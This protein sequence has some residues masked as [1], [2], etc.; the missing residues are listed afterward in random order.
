MK[1]QKASKVIYLE[2]IEHYSGDVNVANDLQQIESS[3]HRLEVKVAMRLV[4]AVA[5]HNI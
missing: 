1:S 4:Q 3:D 5:Y 2:Y